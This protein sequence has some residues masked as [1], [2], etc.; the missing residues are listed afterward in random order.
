MKFTEALENMKR[1]IPMKLPSWGGYW[2]WDS[3]AETIVMY[4]K[5]NQRLDIR[6]TQRVEYTLLNVLSDEWIPA[7]G[8]NCPNLGGTAQFSFSEA[9]K[10]LKRGMRVARQGWNGNSTAPDG[11]LRWY[12]ALCPGHPLEKGREWALLSPLP[13][14]PPLMRAW[15]LPVSWADFPWPASPEAASRSRPVSISSLGLGCLW[16]AGYFPQPLS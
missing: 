8:D 7:D 2:C 13:V 14:P 4:T 11:D 9:I 12:N 1:G 3:D 15:A 6:E 5:D 16:A 10:Y